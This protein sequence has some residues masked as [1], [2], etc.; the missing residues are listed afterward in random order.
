MK[1][2]ESPHL[3]LWTWGSDCLFKTAEPVSV[4]GDLLSQRS[5][6]EDG[7]SSDMRGKSGV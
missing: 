1:E 3:P 7:R 6:L 4:S 2:S 5:E